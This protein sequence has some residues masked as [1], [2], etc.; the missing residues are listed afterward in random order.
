MNTWNPTYDQLLC[1]DLQHSW[2]PYEARSVKG[3]FERTLRCVR[4]K[5]LKKQS[6]DVQGYILRSEF[7]YTDGYL[8][9]GE[10]RLSRADRAEL[11]VRNLG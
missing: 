7:I 8:R 4:C 9:P 3:G 11:R 1:R 2:S 6:L 5:S 10:G